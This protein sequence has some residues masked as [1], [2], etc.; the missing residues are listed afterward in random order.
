LQTYADTRA[1]TAAKSITVTLLAR[2]VRHGQANAKD[3]KPK[4]GAALVAGNAVAIARLDATV[5][6][7]P[8][9][10]TSSDPELLEATR[11]GFERRWATERQ[12]WRAAGSGRPGA[13][14]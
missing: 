7:T 10:N 9:E 3:R 6:R 13:A 12:L 8:K 5:S 4:R 2:S 1:A 14:R 11:I